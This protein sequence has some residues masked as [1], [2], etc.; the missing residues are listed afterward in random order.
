MKAQI[1]GVF[2]ASVAAACFAAYDVCRD[3]PYARF[4]VA[5]IGEEM[6]ARRP[7]RP[8]DDPVP[9]H[10]FPGPRHG[11]TYV[12]AHRGAHSDRP[13]N[14]LPAYQKAIELG[15]DFVEIDVRRTSDRH[16]VSVHD[17]RIDA[18]VQGD[19]GLVSSFTLA[20]LKAMDIGWSHVPEWKNTRIPTV[21]EILR[22]C[23]GKIG[24]Y[25]DLKE[26]LVDELV[27]LIRSYGMEKDVVW[28][29]PADREQVIT[30]LL[31]QCPD[32]LSMPDPG[33]FSALPA[34]LEAWKPSVVATDMDV[35]SEG[36][37]RRCHSGGAR[38]F[39][40]DRKGSRQEWDYILS[41]G[42]DGIQ[43]DDPGALIRLLRSSA[44]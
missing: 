10:P 28:Y 33:D 14:S 17:E 16:I 12:I 32:C 24:I 25:L 42:T 27:P 19:T 2:V 29:I 23:R 22:L 43:T 1:T 39:V 6:S 15:C 35:L 9:V 38:V 3:S 41:L 21:E 40:D 31:E 4:S 36:F 44:R 7:G 30:D 8:G 26:P 18:Y 5:C 13:E 20:Q 37:V 34:V 11:S